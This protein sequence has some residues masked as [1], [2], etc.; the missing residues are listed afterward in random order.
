[1]GLAHKKSMCIGAQHQR[2][3]AVLRRRQKD[4]APQNLEDKAFSSSGLSLAPSTDK[5]LHF[6][7][8]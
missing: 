8:W 2:K 3:K 6:A 1:M 7:S 4:E 5:D